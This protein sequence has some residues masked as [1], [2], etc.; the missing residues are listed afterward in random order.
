MTQ[1]FDPERLAELQ[2]ESPRQQRR[3]ADR[4]RERREAAARWN[5]R[6]FMD[7]PEAAEEAPPPL[8]RTPHYVERLRAFWGAVALALVVWGPGG[9]SPAP[10]DGDVRLA[11]EYTASVVCRRGPNLIWPTAVEDAQ[12]ALRRLPTLPSLAAELPSAAQA[13]AE[14]HGIAVPSELKEPEYRGFFPVIRLR[15]IP[16]T[17]AYFAKVAAT[18]PGRRDRLRLFWASVWL[19]LG[20]WG[21]GP[22]GWLN[23][24]SRAQAQSAIE[25]TAVAVCSYRSRHLSAAQRQLHGVLADA[26]VMRNR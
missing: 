8:I 21:T 15:E 18:P 6:A 24:T 11:L 3:R 23:Q 20:T 17:L 5:P 10:E 9:P 12:D 22:E 14:V 4:E 1:D 19:A 25:R 7:H 16:I 2:G 13:A 26:Q